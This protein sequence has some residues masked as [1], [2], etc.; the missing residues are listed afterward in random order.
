VGSKSS[1]QQNLPVLN[2][3]CQLT[4]LVVYSWDKTVVVVVAVVVIVG[5]FV[6]FSDEL[7]S[8]QLFYCCFQNHFPS[9]LA[10]C[11]RDHDWC[12]ILCGFMPFLI[13]RG[14]SLTGCWISAFPQLLSDSGVE[15][16]FT[17]MPFFQLQYPNNLK[18]EDEYSS[19]VGPKASCIVV[20]S[21]LA[22]LTAVAVTTLWY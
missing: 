20:P 9:V 12:R 10:S 3:G 2:W 11:H 4:H 7:L 19:G 8:S 1:L 14:Q 13:C 16:L 6:N 18:Y 5:N 21:M 22:L 15:G 17:F